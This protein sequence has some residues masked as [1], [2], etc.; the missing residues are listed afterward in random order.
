[1]FK[2]SEGL[3]SELDDAAIYAVE[4]GKKILSKPVYKEYM[5]KLDKMVNQKPDIYH[6]LYEQLLE[7]YAQ[8]VQQLERSR[9]KNKTPLL[10]VGLRRAYGFI[11]QVSPM[12]W[13]N[14][15]FGFDPDRLIYALYTAALLHGIGRTLQDRKVVQ[16]THEG[17]YQ[18]IWYPN[19]GPLE[20]GHYQVRAT[21]SQPEDYVRELHVVYAQVVMPKLGLAWI[22]EE[23]KLFLW[24]VRALED[25]QAGFGEL[26]IDL[27]VE[28]LA[29]GVGEEFNFDKM[30]PSITPPET[31][32]GEKFLAWLK[33]KL[34]ENS[35]LINQEGSGIYHGKEGLLIE[36]D[37][38][39]AEY[40]DKAHVGKASSEL[41]KSQ[42]ESLGLTSQAE[43]YAKQASSFLQE[44]RHQEFQALLI[45]DEWGLFEKTGPVMNVASQSQ[46]TSGERF[47]SRVGGLAQQFMLAYTS[48]GKK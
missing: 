23:P 32:E 46:I 14:D 45:A 31:L 39:I 7:N 26:E 36:I 44:R 5:E 10:H 8:F 27:D 33:Q 22:T 30:P 18:G 43:R 15:G 29:K 47:F 4:S 9:D 35:K 12:V 34:K 28:K 37:Q 38:L 25:L 40:V 16:C 24:W 19:V 17:K 1:M 48:H 2:D 6:V 3:R 11:R 13:S 21:K 42:F 41:I 20:E